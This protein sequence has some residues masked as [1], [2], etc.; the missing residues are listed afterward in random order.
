MSGKIRVYELARELGMEDSKP[1]IKMLK[2]MGFEV[3]TASSSLPDD[4]VARVREVWAPHAERKQVQAQAAKQKQ[5]EAE[6]AK[7]AQVQKE[8]VKPAG[9]ARVVRIVR[10]ATTEERAALID[11]QERKN[12]GEELVA[13]ATETRKAAAEAMLAKEE[14]PAPPAPVVEAPAPVVAEEPAAVPVV[15]PTR[16]PEL[17]PAAAAAAPI[18]ERNLPPDQMIA[19]EY[20][21]KRPTPVQPV[22]AGQTAVMEQARRPGPGGPPPGVPNRGPGGH[23]GHGPG[24][25]PGPGGPGR[26][27]AGQVIQREIL[28]SRPR[29]PGQPGGPGGRPGGPQ[30]RPG[31]GPRG[32]KGHYRKHA[33]APAAPTRKVVEIPEMIA[34]GEL[35]SRLGISSSEL[36]KYLIKQGQMVTINQALEY[37]QAS[38]IATVYGFEVGQAGDEDID[39]SLLE[40]EDEAH[41]QPRPPVVTVL[42][43]VD[44]GKTSLLDAI[45]ETEVTATE[46]GGI[47]QKIGAYTVHHN[48]K[49]ITF[50]DTPGHEAFTAMR[51]RGAR[52]TDIAILVVAADD[53]IM[54]QTVEAINHARAAKVPIIVAINKID[55]P[56]ANPDKVMQQLTEY[57]L[58]TE[59]WGGDT[60]CVPVSAKQKTGISELLEMVMLTAELGELK[61]NPDRK[62]Q[63]TIIEAW[64]DKGLGPVATVLVQNGTMRVGDTVVVG[65]TW[66]RV[67][68]LL[69]E[70]GEKIRRAGPAIPAEI[71]GLTEVPDAGDYLQVVDD[72]KMAKQVS[73]ART[74]KTRHAR[75]H[76]GSRTTLDDLFAG[77]QAG[78][79]HD[80]KL[81]LKAEGNGSLEALRASLE[82]LTTEEVKLT[83]VHAAVGAISESDIMLASASDAIIIGFN[84]RPDSAVKRLADQEEVDI[85]LYRVIYHVIEDIKKAM[86]GLLSPDIS[87]VELGKVEVRQLFK[88]TKV[89]KVAGCYVTEGKITRDAEIRVVRDGVI[90]YVGKLESLKRFK[91][92]VKEVTEGYE[93]GIQVLNYPDLQEKDI[94]EAFKKE[95]K[96]RESL[97]A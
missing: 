15:E 27:P 54:P 52:V 89:G 93:C 19:A 48:D 26:P 88:I 28:P 20:R 81:L 11:R 87:E 92:D 69:N 62:A 76:S 1:L 9:P 82:K 49:L 36:I 33:S 29:R 85:R 55:K 61:A 45:R 77:I 2:D 7:A 17:A 71:I 39:L 66:G 50:I 21:D 56:Q 22:A 86:T 16:E 44:H 97:H 68:S 42:G 35:A 91:D 43:H 65:N 84:V 94:L 70:N 80:L 37:E 51:A 74:A 58:L 47:T 83:I 18:G 67:R 3:K 5:E 25:G 46:A 14:P 6:K 12:R 38:Q 40:D 34:V 13:S 64:L 53:G 90:A 73:E 57:N 10:H 59:A 30:G 8:P 72:E 23:P 31:G 79:V 75:I 41:L 24:H 4:V 60:I 63:G 78:E 32:K 95:Y 96:E